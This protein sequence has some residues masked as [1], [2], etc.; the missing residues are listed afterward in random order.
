MSNDREQL[1]EANRGQL[2]IVNEQLANLE[3]VFKKSREYVCGIFVEVSGDIAKCRHILEGRK[4]VMRW[5]ELEDMALTEPEDSAEFQVLLAEKG[6]KAI[7]DRRHFLQC[8]P[9]YER[10]I[11]FK[12]NEEGE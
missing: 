5:R 3:K 2:K 12:Q 9:I 4:N 10:E 8:I 1:D 7:L 6:W 11:I